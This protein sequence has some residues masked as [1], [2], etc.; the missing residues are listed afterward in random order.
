VRGF[1]AEE[2][3]R[4]REG[5]D[6]FAA[7]A[8]AEEEKLRAEK[9]GA[10][11]SPPTS[12]GEPKGPTQG[13]LA[14]WSFEEKNRESARDGSPNKRDA[15]LRGQPEFI[16]NG[17]GYAAIRLDGKDDVLSVPN[18]LLR[19]AA[20]TIALWIRAERGDKTIVASAGGKHTIR[21]HDGKL[22]ATCYT[23]KHKAGLFGDGLL[24]PGRWQHAALVWQQ[25][26]EQLLYV[27]GRVA[28]RRKVAADDQIEKPLHLLLGKPSA[29]SDRFF[30]FDA[31]EVRLYDRALSA[32]E[33][34]GLVQLERR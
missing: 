26:K 9:K 28:G 11:V 16:D 2:E 6:S 15:P 20:G 22:A 29:E 5:L 8:R 17:V 32:D 12:P 19:P 13:L 30:A 4:R 24:K 7:M 31:D 25:G 21:I 10:A 33:I 14:C 27:D 18:E 1:S 3:A 34:A 23:Q